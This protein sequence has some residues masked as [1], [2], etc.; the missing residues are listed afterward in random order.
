MKEIHHCLILLHPVKHSMFTRAIFIRPD[1][2][3]IRESIC[4]CAKLFVDEGNVHMA[5]VQSWKNKN[6]D[7]FYTKTTQKG[8]FSKLCVKIKKRCYTDLL[9][10]STRKHNL[11]YF[12]GRI[13]FFI[14]SFFQEK[15]LGD[16]SFKLETKIM[17]FMSVFFLKKILS[18][19][20]KSCQ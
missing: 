4:A 10:F 18:R 9:H 8:G 20:L 1:S 17:N 6:I 16:I 7:E 13:V 19:Q 11:V 12:F 15:T 3:L 2:E 14:Y 5:Q